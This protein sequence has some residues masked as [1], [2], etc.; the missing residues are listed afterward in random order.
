MAA[1]AIP[2]PCKVFLPLFLLA[3]SLGKLSWSQNSAPLTELHTV[4][5]FITL[6]LSLCTLIS[7]WRTKGK[8]EIPEHRTRCLGTSLPS[9]SINLPIAHHAQVTLVFFQTL[10]HIISYLRELAILYPLHGMFL[11]SIFA[12]LASSL[13]FMLLYKCHLLKF[14]IHNLS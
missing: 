10:G 5:A 7:L 2:S 14:C 9:T 12:M 13:A 11:P 1:H 4:V 8:T 3:N 6:Q